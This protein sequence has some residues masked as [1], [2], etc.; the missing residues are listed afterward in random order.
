MSMSFAEAREWRRSKPFGC[1]IVSGLPGSGKSTIAQAISSAVESYGVGWPVR[2]KD[3][4]LEQL[5]P[6][7]A[8]IDARERRRL[9]RIADD[10]LIL[11][12]LA[13]PYGMT[14]SWW[15][16]PRST[17]DSGT[18]IDWFARIHTRVVELHCAC[19]PEV[20][21]ARFLS[22]QR[23]PAHLDASRSPDDVLTT[24]V[25][26]AALGPLGFGLVVDVRTDV[27]VDV[28]ATT[29]ALVRSLLQT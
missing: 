22:R 27:D 10:Q 2:D 28:A 7:D 15:R 4:L 9:S 18:P 14:V 12:T 13:D 11:R 21:A 19:R 17:R 8:G 29:E 6:V 26:Q 24:F 16:H 5:F 25:E 3:D 20:A 23:H 1:V